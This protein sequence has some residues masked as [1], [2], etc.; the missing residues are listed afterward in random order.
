MKRGELKEVLSGLKSLN[1]LT[2]EYKCAYAISRNIDKITSEIKRIVEMNVAGEGV[3]K[4]DDERIDKLQPFLKKDDDGNNVMENGT[5]A[6][7]QKNAGKWEKI[8]KELEKKYNIL[9]IDKARQDIELAEITREANAA[10][11][12]NRRL[13]AVVLEMTLEKYPF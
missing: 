13:K 2:G 10:I 4:F 3:K 8:Y 6:F 5:T 7:D 1:T 12:E 11:E 9:L